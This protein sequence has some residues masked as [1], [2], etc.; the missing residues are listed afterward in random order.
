MRDREEEKP[1]S[2]R[3]PQE[4]D[5]EMREEAPMTIQSLETLREG[6]S[7]L[8]YLELRHPGWS[9][10]PVED[11]AFTLPGKA[12]H[13]A[14]VGMV[15]LAG[16]Y[17]KGQRP[18]NT[19][20]GVVPPRLRAMRF[21]DRGD[22]SVR[23]IAADCNPVDLII[24]HAHYDH[25]EAD[26]DINCVFPLSPLLEL[27]VEEFIGECSPVYYSMMGYI[28]EAD[29]VLQTAAEEIIPGLKS[30]DV[31][32]VVVSG[33]CAL[34]HQTAA[35]IQRQV[36]QAGIPTVGVSVCPDITYRMQVPRAVA[37]RFPIGNPFGASMDNSMHMRI[38]KE[39][40]SLIETARK[41]G[42]VVPLPYEWAKP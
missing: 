40:L 19:S 2:P 22:W 29:L 36:E 5:D 42:E 10:Q 30:H 6:Y 18:F 27:E 12:L 7:W 33:G 41:P 15:S 17:L 26:E 4:D 24:A 11:F 9:P 38:L 35:L 25:M 28:P 8:R 32:F 23:E 31:D 21:R 37:L 3:R 16:V 34:S 13:E 39:A 14:R 1:S 20:P